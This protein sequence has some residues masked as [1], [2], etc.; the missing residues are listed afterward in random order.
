MPLVGV[1][2]FQFPKEVQF[3]LLSEVFFDPFIKH[4]STTW[5]G[6]FERVSGRPV[7]RDF[8]GDVPGSETAP[9]FAQERQESFDRAQL[10][11]SESSKQISIP[12]CWHQ[13]VLGWLIVEFARVDDHVDELDLGQIVGPLAC[14]LAWSESPWSSRIEALGQLQSLR[15]QYSDFDWIGIYRLPSQTSKTLAL[16]VYIGEHTEHTEIPL[17][18]GICGA[19]VREEKTLNISNVHED[20]RFIACSIKTQSELV[21]PIRTSSNRITAEIDIDSNTPSNFSP[22]KV[23]AV[24]AAADRL[25]KISELFTD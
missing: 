6:L 25:G 8:R 14:L 22:E 12:L 17:E 19:A 20:P 23:A 16:S 5:I 13:E 9:V 11:S 21:V 3:E 18:S 1:S 7:L 2:S 10:I 4:H 24:E 15:N